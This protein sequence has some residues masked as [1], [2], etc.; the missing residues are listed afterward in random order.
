MSSTDVLAS[1]AVEILC[2][3]EVRGL[4]CQVTPEGRLRVGPAA[5]LSPDLALLIQEHRD[6]LITLTRVCDRGVQ[7]RVEAFHRQIDAAPI[8]VVLPELLFRD[9]VP[10]REGQCFSCGD[11]LEHARF[12]RCWRCALAW[13]VAARVPLTRATLSDLHAGNTS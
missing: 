11:P 7:A 13:R 5:R 1:P 12:G 4:T 8:G 10:L 9:D 6:D 2:R 3:L